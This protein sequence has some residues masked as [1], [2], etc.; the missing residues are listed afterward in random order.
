ML[1]A[2]AIVLG[3]LWALGMT[4]STSVGGYVHVLL[5]VAVVLAGYG[6]IRRQRERRHS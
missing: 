1:W 3:G 5:A 6:I 2:I 4:S